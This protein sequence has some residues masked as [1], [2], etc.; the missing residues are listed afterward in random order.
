MPT[1]ESTAEPIA[2]AGAD[3]RHYLRLLD[4]RDRRGVAAY[5]LLSLAC[6]WLGSAAALLLVPLITPGTVSTWWPLR[7]ATM[8]PEAQI[9]CFALASTTFALVRWYT[10]RAGARLS[11]RYGARLRT[12]VHA[13]LMETTLDGLQ[14]TSS[15][16]I[17]HVLTYNAEVITQGFNALLQLLIAA[18]TAL[19]S[20]AIAWWIA[21]MPMIAVPVVLL[22]ALYAMRANS[23]EQSEVSRAYVAGMTELFWRSEEFTRRWRHVRSFGRADEEKRHYARN[24]ADLGQG[25]RRQQ[26]LLAMG[27]LNLELLA[28]AGIATIFWM[29]RRWQGADH[30]ALIG[31]CLLLGRLLPYLTSTRQCLQQLRSA[32]PA[33]TLWWQ[34]RLLPLEVDPLTTT[35]AMP[36][37]TIKRLQ[38]RQ[39]ITLELSELVLRPGDLVVVGGPS[40]IGKSSLMDALAGLMQ[41][42]VFEALADGALLGFDGYRGLV[43][44]GAYVSQGVR[45]WQETVRDALSWADPAASEET[46]VDALHAVG[47]PAA[48]PRRVSSLSGGELQRV[49]LAQVILRQPF[50]AILDEATSALDATSEMAVLAQVKRRMVHGVLV[51]VSHRT[52]VIALA[53]HCLMVEQGNGGVVAV[54]QDRELQ[55]ANSVM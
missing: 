35:M 52:N 48:L 23:R 43:G 3:L 19:V 5:V 22:L 37:V 49:L 54:L 10:A 42:A 32:S 2:R 15:A 4:A 17:A 30:A 26:D 38:L 21:P 1:V 27:R 34:H 36:V 29:A 50:L 12:Q 51:V 25:Y 31:V 24:S 39:P 13:R 18:L 33:W 45:P 20:I 16:E 55:A 53:D 47:F 41:P 44:H 8:T 9:L 28:T 40:G 14:R 6:A 46:M 11:S 7:M